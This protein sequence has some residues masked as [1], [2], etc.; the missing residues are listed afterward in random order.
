MYVRL[1]NKK[2]IRK[3]FSFFISLGLVLG[4]A[5]ISPTVSAKE[6]YKTL[7]SD[8]KLE[9]KLDFEKGEFRNI[10]IREGA[11]GAELETE[12]GETGEYITPIAEA[13]FEAN[14]VG[15]HWKSKDFIEN[16]IRVAVQF[17]EDGVNF[18]EW[19]NTSVELDETRDDK[20][21]E[22]IFAA[23][24]GVENKKFARAK[25]EFVG[26][27]GKFSKLNSFT[28]TFINS[29][30]A[31]KRTDKKL[32]LFKKS[33]AGIQGV[34][35]TSSG[36]QN[37]NV[38]SREEWGADESYRLDRKGKEE[39]PRS[40]HGTRKIII[41]HTATTAS[42]GVTDF[43][44]NK[45]AVRAAYYYHAVTENW[46]DIGYNALVDAS[47]NV[48]EGRYGTHGTSATRDNPT[49]EQ[50]MELDVEAGHTASYNSGSFGVS[51]LGN[52]TSYT[53]PIEQENALRDVIAY[54]ADSRGID[55]QGSSD[56]RRY[57]GLWHNDMFNVGTH[58]E[59]S[60]AYTECPGSVLYADFQQKIKTPA[61]QL[62]GILTNM[63]GF[64]ATMGGVPISGTSIG[65][66]MINFDWD[67]FYGATE[68]QYVLERVFGTTGVASDSEPWNVAWF[69]LENSNVKTTTAQAVSISGSDLLPNSNYVFYVR[70]V[71][72][73]GNP[74]SNTKHVN[75]TRNSLAIAD[76]IAPVVNIISPND[77]QAVSGTVT[78]SANATDNIGV[79]SI[80]LYIDNIKK[81]TVLGGNLTYS[82]I[83]K[84][85]PAGVHVIKVK[86][87]DATGNSAEKL[88]SVTK[89]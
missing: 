11:E 64:D 3:V 21:N 87:Y 82:W 36:G 57:D 68:Y 23:L 61:D 20:K 9:T 33:V 50:I 43:E 5:G 39:W 86:A 47:G 51:A 8:K 67:V 7:A 6:T 71:D 13:S 55:I 12:N 58:R 56:F 25:V 81:T 26:A 84:K 74:V 22:E 1:W 70:G 52:F 62:P 42:N 76:L 78:I 24:V 83:T 2:I 29:G 79:K 15:V 46:G 38:V 34:S 89:Y 18:G 72:V 37:L 30:D 4:G 14:Y 69:N 60:S 85:V 35:K 27:E 19:E 75:F 45:A 31:S 16:S 41:H 53:P 10:K 17:S 63:D 48:Y 49:A 54:V 80:E 65:T 44:A 77:G 28:F 73:A 59:F 66:D 88:I 40:Y 32:S